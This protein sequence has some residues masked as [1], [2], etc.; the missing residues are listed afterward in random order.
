MLVDKELARGRPLEALG[1]YQALLR[2]L[3]EVLGMEHRPERFDFGWRYVETQLPEDARNLLAHYAFVADEAA[4]RERAP[5][6]AD[7]LQRRLASALP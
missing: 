6:L 3:L 4:L 7:E 1:F 5:G 2:A